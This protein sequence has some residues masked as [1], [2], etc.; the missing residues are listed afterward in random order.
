MLRNYCTVL[1]GA[2]E[3][4][5]QCPPFVS[6]HWWGQGK[7][8]LS[9]MQLGSKKITEMQ[10]E[11][12]ETVHQTNSFDGAKQKESGQVWS[13]E[14]LEQCWSVTLSEHKTFPIHIIEVYLLHL[15]LALPARSS[16]KYIRFPPAPQFYPHSNPI[17]VGQAEK[18]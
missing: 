14:S 15:Y 11:W 6:G 5:W 9:L 1:V 10:A 7:G 4:L 12:N 18:V 8:K 17:M 16:R 3:Q 2:V 13:N